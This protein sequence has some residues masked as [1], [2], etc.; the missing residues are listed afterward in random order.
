MKRDILGIATA[1][2]VAAVSL[3]AVAAAPASASSVTVSG[4]PN[5]FI[6]APTGLHNAPS[7]QAPAAVT[8]EAGTPV[9]AL[10]FIP[11]GE[12]QGQ[13]RLVPD[14][15]R[16]QARLG[17]AGRHRRNAG[18]APL[19]TSQP[20]PPRSGSDCIQCGTHSRVNRK[21]TIRRCVRGASSR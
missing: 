5:S 7:T 12:V 10:C 21:A 9:Y 6:S 1:A 13:Q 4:T 20:R 3:V 14:L 17:A 16:R 15:G 2:S 11:D 19:R 18:A 8:L